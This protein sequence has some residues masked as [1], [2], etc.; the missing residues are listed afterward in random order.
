MI[1]RLPQYFRDELDSWTRSLEFHNRELSELVRLFS[2]AMDL[3]VISEDCEKETK[4]MDQ[5]MVQQ[6]Q[7][8]HLAGQ[9]AG[10][11]LR[12]EGLN[13]TGS[14]DEAVSKQQTIL[15]TKMHSNERTFLRAKYACTEHLASLFEVELKDQDIPERSK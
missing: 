14:I 11:R 5:L 15:H 2:V 8:S 3:P 12:L 10:Q 13:P 1:Y 4:F 9:I 6:Q 7:F